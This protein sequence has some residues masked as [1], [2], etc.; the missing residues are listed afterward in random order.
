MGFPHVACFF[1]SRS[2]QNQSQFHQLK[3]ETK[4]F[5]GVPLRSLFFF[6]RVTP[7]SESDFNGAAKNK[8]LP[9]EGQQLN[10]KY[11][12]DQGRVIILIGTGYR[13]R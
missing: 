6:V 2:L 3:S 12:T 8:V 9:T 4:F 13:T 11:E 10:S 5:K 1:L 7:E